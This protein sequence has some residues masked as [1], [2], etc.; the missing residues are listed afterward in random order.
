MRQL[1]LQSM[2]AILFPEIQTWSI[3]FILW[4]LLMIYFILWHSNFLNILE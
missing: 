1:C 3:N 4:H 2:A